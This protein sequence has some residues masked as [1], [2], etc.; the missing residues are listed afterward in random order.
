LSAISFF[1]FITGVSHLEILITEQSTSRKFHGLFH[2]SRPETVPM[3]EEVT[4]TLSA[5]FVEIQ[6]KSSETKI[7]P[8]Q[9]QS[10]VMLEVSFDS[11]SPIHYE[12]IQEMCTINKEICI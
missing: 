2:I 3:L 10:K 4:H 12:C 8:R 5:M 6:I 11:Y 1:L 7:L 9:E